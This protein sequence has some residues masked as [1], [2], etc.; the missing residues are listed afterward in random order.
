MYIM[1]W[2]GIKVAT[3]WRQWEIARS[4]LW[5]VEYTRVSDDLDVGYKRKRIKDNNKLLL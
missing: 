4:R 2:L 5:I 1:M 3:Q